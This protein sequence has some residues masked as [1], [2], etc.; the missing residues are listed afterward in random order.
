[1]T[2][3]GHI[4]YSN[5]FPPHAGIVT[6][7]TPLPY[8]VVEG[9]PSELNRL[10]ANGE[11]QVSPSSSIEYASHPGK[12]VILPGLSITSRTEVRSIILQSR[13]PMEEL[14]GKRVALTAASATSVVLL[15]VLLE[16]RHGLRPVYSAFRQGVDDPFGTVDAMLFIGDL[17]LQTKATPDYPYRCDLGAHWHEFTGLPFVYA[18]WQVNYEKTIAKELAVLYDIIMRSKRYGLSDIPAL[19]AAHAARFRLPVQ[20]LSEYWSSFSYDLTEYEMKG[21][22]TF[23]EYAAELGAIKRVGDITLWDGR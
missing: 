12:Y 21:L 16:L 6:G 3:L 22:R 13:M 11:I 18:L 5:C 1:M 4:T 2:K 23:Y 7:A 15:R 19:A 9:I 17:A 14:N 20:L 8:P 10:L